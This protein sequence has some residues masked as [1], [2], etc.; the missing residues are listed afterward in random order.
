M[1]SPT[2]DVRRSAVS[3][4]PTAF[5]TVLSLVGPLE[6]EDPER[7]TRALEAMG[8]TCGEIRALTPPPLE[9]LR[10]RVRGPLDPARLIEEVFAGRPIGVA[11]RPDSV[12]AI[13][14]GLWVMDVDSTLIEDEAIDELARAA[15]RYDEVAR[16]TE[17]AMNGELDFESALRERCRHLAGLPGSVFDEVRAR[18]TVRSGARRLIA[19]LR[20]VGCKTVVVSG[21][22]E[23]TVGPLAR[24][25]GI[26]HFRANVLEVRDGVLTGALVGSIVDGARKRAYL[27]DLA[28]QYDVPRARIVAVGDGAND[29]PMLEAAGL[30]VAFCAKPAVRRRAAV[31]VDLPRLDAVAHHLGWSTS[32]LEELSAQLRRG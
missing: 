27:E 2:E 31:T 9:A 28:A 22:F 10:V 20:A 30:G 32:D 25:L 15:G 23:Q 4:A 16:V 19:A 24:E 5:P 1:R 6:P 12:A 26:D 21:G 29:L 14:P 11:V 7:V 3:R 13:V 17:R 18:L 8:A